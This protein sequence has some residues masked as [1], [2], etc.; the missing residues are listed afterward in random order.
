MGNK[1]GRQLAQQLL[2]EDPRLE[3]IYMSGYSA[4]VFGK[5]FT[6]DEDV[7]FITKPSQTHKLAQI[8][9]NCL[10]A[11]IELKLKPRNEL[12]LSPAG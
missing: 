2:L 7:N 10:D 3:V 8:V 5:D 12:A 4:E 6:F 9:R 1:S 11:P